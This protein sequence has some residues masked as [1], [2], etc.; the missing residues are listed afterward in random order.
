MT[1]SLSKYMGSPTAGPL[2]IGQRRRLK[3]KI[4]ALRLVNL[5]MKIT[6]FRIE[7][8]NVRKEDHDIS[9]STLQPSDNPGS[10]EKKHFLNLH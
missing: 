10:L 8:I 6:S 2:E 4:P 1:G 7:R 3:V 5:R 9:P